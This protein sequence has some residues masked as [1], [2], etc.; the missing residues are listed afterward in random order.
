MSG[1]SPWIWVSLGLLCLLAVA[2][3]FAIHYYSESVYFKNLYERASADLEK[4]TFDLRKMV[5]DL[6][7]L[8]IKVNVLEKLTMKV[9]ILI[10]YGNGTLIWY[11][12]TSVPRETNV[13]M[14]TK[15]IAVVEGKEY[16]EMGIFVEAI[17]GVRNEG[18]KYWIWYM[19]NPKKKDWEWGPVASDKYILHEGD[20][21][22]WKYGVPSF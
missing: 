13:L 14:A 17:N 7:D 15:V 12:G 8:T 19:W 20:T 4:L 16:P 5:A 1:K 2:A 21:I 22:M 3:Y 9:N 6:E 11:N 18:G 10:D